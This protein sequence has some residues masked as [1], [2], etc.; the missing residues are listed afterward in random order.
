VVPFGILLGCALGMRV[1]GLLLV[2]YAGLIMLMHM[3]RLQLE[4]IRGRFGFFSQS[5]IALAPAFL[6]RYLIMIAVWP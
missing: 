5:V 2:G 1:L 6:I 3:Q 4:P